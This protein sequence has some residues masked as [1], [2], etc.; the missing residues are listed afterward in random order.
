VRLRLVGRGRRFRRPPP[1]SRRRQPVLSSPPGELSGSAPQEPSAPPVHPLATYEDL[2][3]RDVFW[4][5]RAYEDACDRVALRALL[6][7]AGERLIEVGAGFGRLAG[8]YAGYAEVTLLDAS[9]IHV[10]AA[11]AALDGDERFRISL[12]DALALPYPDGHFDAAVCVR[13]LHHFGDPGPVLA[14]LGRVVRP[15][16]VLVLEFANKRNLKAIARH[17]VDRQRWSPF[18]LDSVEYKPYHFDHA[19]VLVRRR[20]AAAGFRTERT[21]AASLFRIPWLCR[22]FPASFLAGIESMLQ[23][24]LGSITPGPSVFLMAR[25][26]SR[27]VE[28]DSPNPVAWT[29]GS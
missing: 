20:L 22:R 3:Y 21:R 28:G 7:P 19:P 17:V 14:E 13:M 25:R 4:A 24:P 16:G 15:S 12:G 23:E 26:T 27:S 29:G 10:E 9:E 8:E 1:G 11:R 18:D 5:A 6:P 2:G